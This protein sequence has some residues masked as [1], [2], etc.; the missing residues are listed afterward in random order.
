MRRAS[1][2]PG[3]VFLRIACP[4]Y[5][6]ARVCVCNGLQAGL[7]TTGIVI[8]GGGGGIAGKGQLWMLLLLLLLLLLVA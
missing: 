2:N 6:C 4:A 3:R 1:E 5:L 8:G 7:V